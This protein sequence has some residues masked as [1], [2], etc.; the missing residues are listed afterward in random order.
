MMRIGQKYVIINASVN[1]VK[2]ITFYLKGTRS[3]MY[4]LGIKKRVSFQVGTKHA[5][6]H[7]FN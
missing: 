1:D 7:M 3:Q 6:Y 5:L 2:K 4:L